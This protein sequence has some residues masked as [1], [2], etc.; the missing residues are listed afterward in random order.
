MILCEM[1]TVRLFGLDYL[2]PGLLGISFDFGVLWENSL[3][4]ELFSGPKGLGTSGS[5]VFTPLL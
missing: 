4:H 5:K 2:L 3:G 1:G